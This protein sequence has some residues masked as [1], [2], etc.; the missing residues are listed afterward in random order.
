VYRNCGT[1]AHY[2][3]VVLGGVYSRHE[4]KAVLVGIDTDAAALNVRNDKKSRVVSAPISEGS[5]Q[6]RL[7]RECKGD[8]VLDS[9]LRGRRRDE[10]Q[11]EGSASHPRLRWRC[12]TR[13]DGRLRTHS[14]AR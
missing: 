3:Q 2:P 13:L 8:R 9:N 5:L 14:H 10:S 1:L 6:R 4:M 7:V 12:A 11:D